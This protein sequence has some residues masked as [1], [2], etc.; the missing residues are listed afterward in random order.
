MDILEEMLKT[1]EKEGFTPT[2]NIEKI[3]RA[4]KMMFGEAEWARCPCD[5]NN[6]ARSC[7]SELC[8]GDIIKDGI[9]HCRCYKK[10]K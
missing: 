8:R 10:E 6:P 7:I 1:C 2:E 3:A 5:G 9:C 4:K